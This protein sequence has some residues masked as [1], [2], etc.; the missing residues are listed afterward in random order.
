LK[1]VHYWGM[2]KRYSGYILKVVFYISLLIIVVV[3]N[4][5]YI[6]KSTNKIYL[7]QRQLQY[8][9]EISSVVSVSYVTEFESFLSNDTN[10]IM[11]QPPFSLWGQ[12]NIQ[13]VQ[14]QTNIYKEFQLENGDY[15]PEISQI[16]FEPAN[17]NRFVTYEQMYCFFLQT[18]G[19]PTSMVSALTQFKNLMD[20]KYAS[21]SIVNRTSPFEMLLTSFDD[22]YN[23][24]SSSLVA[25]GSAHLING[26]MSDKL[27]ASVDDLSHLGTT[28]LIIFSLTLA[29][30]SVLIWFQILRKVKEVNNDFKKVLAILPPNTVLSSF[31]LKSFL[32]K[33]SN[34]AQT[35]D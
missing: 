16:L 1:V 4:Y 31:L 15:D 28:I 2:Q 11:G 21:Y 10:Y 34:I 12:L 13:L 27:A 20:T 35:L 9:N 33:T 5:V 25:A 18:E 23:I 3:L 22:L 19:K 30:V 8:A 32:K 14:I 6:T 24:L 29:V 7:Q 17:C 26:I